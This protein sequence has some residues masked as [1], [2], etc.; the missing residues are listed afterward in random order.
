MHHR[1]RRCEGGSWCADGAKSWQYSRALALQPA[2]IRALEFQNLDYLKDFLS[3]RTA[4]DGE[5]FGEAWVDDFSE[6]PSQV[7]HPQLYRLLWKASFKHP[8]S[9][10]VLECHTVFSYLKH[11][12]ET[13]RISG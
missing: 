12:A 2:R 5:V 1:L 13:D 8:S 4:A 6:V 10:H 7:L 3:V 9:I 11:L